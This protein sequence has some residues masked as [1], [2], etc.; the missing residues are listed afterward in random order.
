MGLHIAAIN[1]GSNGNCYYI[2]TQHEAILVD[3]GIS[4]K[5][6]ERRIDALGLS[7]SLVKAIWVTHEHI[8]HIR[9]LE[10]L[11][12][13]Y[14]LPVFLT[15]GTLARMRQRPE[16]RN[17]HLIEANS[18]TC[19]GEFTIDTFSKY[20]DAGD[21][22]SVV[23]ESKGIRVGVFTDLGRVCESLKQHFS[24]CHAAFL[25]ANYDGEMLEKGRY[26][27]HLKHRIRGG[28]GHLS[29]TEALAL[30]KEHKPAYMSHLILA[31]LSAENNC[32]QIVQQL[33]DPHA[34]TAEITVASRTAAGPLWQV[35]GAGKV[36]EEPVLPLRRIPAQQLTLF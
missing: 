3:A 9:G 13:K 2:G 31:H 32:P 17:L 33:F 24:G 20:H 22:F 1:S 12:R 5:E 30:V 11:S 26:P 27:Y 36:K 15:N 21:P 19:F 16:T 25:E 7:F 8:D 10:Q 4:C 28:N 6:T 18:R 29:N 14:D 35:H 23:V 34:G